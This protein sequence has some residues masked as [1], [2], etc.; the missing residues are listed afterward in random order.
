MAKDDSIG[1][2]KISDA[3]IDEFHQYRR[4]VVVYLL[5]EEFRLNGLTLETVHA[6]QRV[7]LTLKSRAAGAKPA[8]DDTPSLAHIYDHLT[9]GTRSTIKIEDRHKVVV[10]GTAHVTKDTPI[11]Q[12]RIAGWGLVRKV[13]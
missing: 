11:F 13:V 2:R 9:V 3:L 5:R 4:G 12:K 1:I 7:Q 6:S 10:H 8:S